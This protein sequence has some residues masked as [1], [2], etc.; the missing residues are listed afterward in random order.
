[1]KPSGSKRKQIKQVKS[2]KPA[3][4]T[5]PGDLSILETRH[6]LTSSVH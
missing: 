1:M 6:Q 2:V 4:L 3:M 5:R